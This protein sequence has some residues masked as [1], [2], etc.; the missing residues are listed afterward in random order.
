[1]LDTLLS[2]GDRARE[3][4]LRLV[5]AQWSALGADVDADLEASAAIDPEA[6][7]LASLGLVDRDRS[8]AMVLSWWAGEGPGLLSVQRMRNLAPSYPDRVRYRLG[9]FAGYAWKIGG[10]HRWKSLARAPRSL[11]AVDGG[12]SPRL[13]GPG[14][15]L[16][17]RLGLGVGIKA[18]LVAVLLGLGGW[19][20]VRA[21]TEATGYTGRAVRR[22]AADLVRGGWIEVL[23][24]GPSEYRAPSDRWL[25]LLDLDGPP[26]WRH[27]HDR[28]AFVLAV[29]GWLRG[30]GPDGS[31]EPPEVARALVEAHPTAFKWAGVAVPG[32]EGAAYLGSWVDAVTELA[33][34]LA[35]SA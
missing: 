20:T 17:L 1:M 14:V 8:L 16:R 21:V 6:L 19:H 33:D 5:R 9:E 11:P 32:G 2:V 26:S 28:L 4:A 25:P 15:L 34:G 12:P 22:A 24:A 30:E 27:W 31:S 3:H 35:A 18:D 10:D 23:P 7:V 29:D 13:D